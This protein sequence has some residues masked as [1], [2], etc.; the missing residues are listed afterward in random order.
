MSLI[1][2][3]EQN[4]LDK[5]NS[6]LVDMGIGWDILGS[7]R[8]GVIDM[9]A[10][11]PDE[12]PK[13]PRIIGIYAGELRF[14]MEMGWSW[15]WDM[16]N[17]FD[18]I[19]MW[20]NTWIVTHYPLVNVYI[21]NW[22]D[23][24]FYSWVNPLF[25]LGHLAIFHSFF[26]LCLP[27]RVYRWIVG[28]SFPQYLVGYFEQKRKVILKPSRWEAKENKKINKTMDFKHVG[29]YWMAIIQIFFYDLHIH[30]NDSNRMNGRKP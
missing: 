11:T 5:W 21:A 7:L 16:L 19:L 8:L 2:H 20:Q 14:Q 30:Y 22:K 24:Q 13:T 3:R 18:Q 15:D 6:W 1:K 10:T 23:P 28:I 25:R 4:P 26:Y 27:G 17:H 9:V 29:G 12:K